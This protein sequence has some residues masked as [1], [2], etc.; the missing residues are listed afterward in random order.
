[1]TSDPIST[2]CPKFDPAKWDDKTFEWQNKPF[3]KE[4]IPTFFHVPFPPMINRAMT[5]MWQMVENSGQAEADKSNILV[6]FSDPTPFRSDMYISAAG[7]VPKAQNVTLSGT[8]YAK[9]FDGGYNAVPQFIKQLDTHLAQ[10][11]KKAKGYYIHYAYCPKCSKIYGHNH[12]I[13]FAKL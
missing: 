12:M 13:I 1:M 7:S 6:L 5:R 9:V 3:I 2:C 4:S 10:T 11:S 8:F